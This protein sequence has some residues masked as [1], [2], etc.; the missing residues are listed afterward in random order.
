[1]TEPVKRAYQRLLDH[2]GP[3]DWWPGDSPLEVMIGA[4]LTQ[5]TN[6]KNVEKAIANLRD[7]DLLDVD[8]LYEL[9]TEELAELIRPAGYYRL[10]ADRLH[11]LITL[12]VERYGGSIE[13]MRSLDIVDLREQLLSVNGVGPETADAILLYAL[14]R[15]TFVVDTYTHR[16]AARHGWID[17][18]AGY[19]ELQELFG[20]RLPLDAAMFNEYHALLVRVGKQHCGRRPKCEGCPL[21]PMLADGGP[22]EPL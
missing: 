14:R 18:S 16:V 1:M 3:Q 7:A 9:P 11:N 19:D 21:E 10:K 8:A 17:F 12:L 13:S 5:N 15:P 20:S 6:W 2:F 22:L 4:V